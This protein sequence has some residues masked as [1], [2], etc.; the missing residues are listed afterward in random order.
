MGWRTDDAYERARE[1]EERR[2]VATLAPRDR[3]WLRVWQV[4]RLTL[5]VLGL[6]ALYGLLS[7][8]GFLAAA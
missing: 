2:W 3:L 8:A 7:G 4:W 6:A 1:A 5:T